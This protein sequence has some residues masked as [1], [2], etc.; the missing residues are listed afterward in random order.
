MG[1]LGQRIPGTDGGGGVTRPTPRAI[2]EQIADNWDRCCG[3]GQVY[4]DIEVLISL[5]AAAI[6]GER[7]WP[8]NEAKPR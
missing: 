7:L 3:D 4:D 5:I 1:C 8:P 2:A 6:D